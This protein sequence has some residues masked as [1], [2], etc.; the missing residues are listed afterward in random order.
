MLLT[1]YATKITLRYCPF[2]SRG[3]VECLTRLIVFTQTTFFC[4]FWFIIF[5]KRHVA[6]K[7]L[8]SP[9]PPLEVLFLFAE[10]NFEIG[11]RG[12]GYIWG[13]CYTVERIWSSVQW[14]GVIFLWHPPPHPHTHTSTAKW[15]DRSMFRQTL[16]NDCIMTSGY[17][18]RICFHKVQYLLIFM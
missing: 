7:I 3:W 4:C 8:L 6:S 17:F 13:R 15:K 2:K 10:T 11:K 9:P 1:E 14:W 16:A 5:I 12:R 18:G